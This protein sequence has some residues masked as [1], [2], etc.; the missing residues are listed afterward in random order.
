MSDIVPDYWNDVL[1]LVKVFFP[2]YFDQTSPDFVPS[3]MFDALQPIADEARPW[4][5]SLERQNFAEAMFLAYLIQVQKETSS[6]QGFVPYAGPITSE[7]EGDIAVTY[8]A[9]T[10]NQQS[11][12][13]KR[14]SSDPWDAWN[15]MW[16]ICAQGAIT[17]RF[18]DPCRP[19]ST[20]TMG[21][22]ELSLTLSNCAVALLR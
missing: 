15:R 8:A 6:G 2:Q 12:M 19:S 3:E 9:I 1:N 5:L 11:N 16:S 21:S 20:V 14:P 4:C 22:Q 17:T 13:S 18:G 7:K 10:S